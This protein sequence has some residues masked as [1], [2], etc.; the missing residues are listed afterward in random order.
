MEEG[1]NSISVIPVQSEIKNAVCKAVRHLEE[2]CKVKVRQE[3]FTELAKGF[4]INYTG[5]IHYD[6]TNPD[7][8]N[9]FKDPK[10]S[11]LFRL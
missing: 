1:S 10:V 6:H 9:G 8:D 4:F 5:L 7:V 3:K 2:N 11:L